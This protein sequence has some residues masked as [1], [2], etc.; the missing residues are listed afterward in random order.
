[1]VE[2]PFFLREG[3]IV[4]GQEVWEEKKVFGV[5]K[6]T[7]VEAKQKTRETEEKA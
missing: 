6:I 4:S 3:C 7:K 5:A 2:E 1:M